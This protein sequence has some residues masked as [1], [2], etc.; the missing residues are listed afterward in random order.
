MIY[1]SIMTMSPPSGYVIFNQLFTIHHSLITS[2]EIT[3]FLQDLQDCFNASPLLKP[4]FHSIVAF[5]TKSIDTN[6]LVL[7][8]SLNGCEAFTFSRNLYAYYRKYIWNDEGSEETEVEKEKEVEVESP[9]EWS[10]LQIRQHLFQKYHAAIEN[11]FKLACE[12]GM[13]KL[14]L[15]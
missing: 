11:G 6:L 9:Q 7:D 12:A 14:F 4:F 3:L 15:S 5:G 8:P 10:G 2:S 1:N 13:G